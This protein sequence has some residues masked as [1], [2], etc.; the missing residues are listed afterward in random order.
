MAT[1]RQGYY[2]TYYGSLWGSSEPLT[3]DQ[4]ESN[5]DYVRNALE[6]L[7]WS[8]NAIAALLGNMENEST[9]NPGRWEGDDVNKGPG[10][11]LVQWTPYSK[12]T[13][14]ATD[15]GYDDPSTMEANLARLQWE[16]ENNTQYYS[17]PDYPLTFE[18]FIA[19]EESPHYL[20]AAFAWNYERSWTVLY[21]S[22]EEKEILRQ[23]RGQDAS[24][25][26]EFLTG[27]PAPTPDT[28]EDKKRKGLSLVLMYAA[29]R[30]R[31]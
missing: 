20:A 28:P 21:G 13:D 23:V 1:V 19:S 8:V 16:R 15:N 2:G 26:Y 10:Y 6:P 3:Q 24:K 7:G 29:T 5:A 22:E 12:F 9:I 25:W 18:E 30:G 11:G 17:T 27:S 31:F 14:W 4:M